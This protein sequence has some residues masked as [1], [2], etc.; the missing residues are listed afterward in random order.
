MGDFALE[1]TPPHQTTHFL[2][3]LRPTIWKQS[4]LVKDLSFQ[5]VIS[6]PEISGLI[7]YWPGAVRKV[8]NKV[9]GSE[10]SHR[11]PRIVLTGYI[12]TG[13]RRL[14]AGRY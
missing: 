6:I 13:A 14:R 10:Y 2:K 12:V 8:V 7:E 9:Q 4:N 3:V 1:T 5:S 11:I